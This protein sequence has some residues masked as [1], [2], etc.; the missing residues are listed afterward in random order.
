MQIDKVINES[1]APFADWLAALVFYELPLGELGKVKVVVLGLAFSAIWFSF[2]FNFINVRGLK[3]SWRFLRKRRDTKAKGEI[4]HFQGFSAAIS[5]TV[6]LGNIAGVA[7]AVTYGGPGVAFWMTVAA[8]FAMTL[9]FTECS[10]GN[11]YRI[12]A[13]DGTV[14]GGGDVLH[15]RRLERTRFARP[16]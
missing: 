13:K 8:F 12:I 5:G 1:V 9:K 2:Y 7:V 4:T 10:L 3:Q 14:L 11:K 15:L 6:G 16:G